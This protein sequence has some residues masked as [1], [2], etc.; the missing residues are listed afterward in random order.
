MRTDNN[1]GSFLPD[2]CE[3]GRVLAVVV[4]AELFAIVLAL[5]LPSLSGDRW[6]ELALLSLYIQWI[7]LSSAGLLCLLRGLISRLGN[8]L[9]AT[10]SYLVLLVVVALFSEIAFQGLRFFTIGLSLTVPDHFDFWS[11]NFII[12]AL[13]SGAILRYF[14]V[15]HQL[16]QKHR[17]EAEARLEALQARIRPH[18]LFNSLNTVAALTRTHPAEA[19]AAVHDLADLFRATLK[20]GR[21][22]INFDDE[23]ALVRSYLDIEQLRLGD[24]LQVEWSV[25]G[26]PEGLQIPLL[27]LQP[28][29]ENAVYHG[30]EPRTDGRARCE[31]IVRWMMRGAG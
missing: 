10:A 12:G 16:R 25:D 27:T 18:F 7:A 1:D 2:F 8:R 15:Q 26:L 17:A 3:R 4:A 24:R 9:A 30:V 11:R 20:E 29:V 22:L 23:L 5:M 28:L 31:L 13:L 14:Y 21:T 6:N 19:E